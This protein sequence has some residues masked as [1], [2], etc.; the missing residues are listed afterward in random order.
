MIGYFYS[1]PHFGHRSII[2]LCKRPFTDVEEMNEE[3]IRMYNET[4]GPEDTVLFVGDVFFMPVPKCE[5]VMQR[6][7]GRKLLV[8]GNHDRSPTTMA[9]MGFDVV[10]QEMYMSIA[11]RRVRVNHYPYW[12]KRGDDNRGKEFRPHWVKGEVL[13]HGHT[14][15]PTRRIG[16]MIHVGVDA[17]DYRPAPMHRVREL[18]EAV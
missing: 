13:V 6:L 4:V 17:W 15:S 2:D 7:N 5:E 18:V 16:N 8:Y 1:D 3:L 14:H 10:A 9:K 12:E 11:D